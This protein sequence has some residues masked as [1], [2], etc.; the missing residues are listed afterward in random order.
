M[1]CLEMT[2]CMTHIP[3]FLFRPCDN[4]VLAYSNLRVSAVDMIAFD[5]EQRKL[6]YYV[7]MDSGT[8]KE[9]HG[10]RYS[11]DLNL[12]HLMSFNILSSVFQLSFITHK[13]SLLSFIQIQ[14]E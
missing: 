3:L 4:E 7:N 2:K 6:C 5:S 13:T 9:L 14:F 11:F 8:S 1:F 12:R 10:R